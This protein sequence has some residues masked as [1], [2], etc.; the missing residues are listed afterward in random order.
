MLKVT[1]RP[2]SSNHKMAAAG[3]ISHPLGGVRE[4]LSLDSQQMSQVSWSLIGSQVHLP[5][6][7]TVAQ[8]MTGPALGYLLSLPTWVREEP[9]PCLD[10]EWQ[11]GTSPNDKAGEDGGWMLVMQILSMHT[12]VFK[13]F[14][15]S[16]SL[17]FSGR[18]LPVSMSCWVEGMLIVL[19]G[20][21][22]TQKGHLHSAQYNW[23]SINYLILRA[24]ASLSGFAQIVMSHYQPR[25]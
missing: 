16:S 8:A 17:P 9:H 12:S 1:Q 4:W 21:F 5:V 6:P 23:W 2:G 19:T 22:C 10:W 14:P 15:S 18:K 20:E 3:P 11:R 25:P 13:F 24:R 7:I